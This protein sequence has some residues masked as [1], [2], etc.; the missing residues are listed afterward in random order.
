M[1]L[2]GL[3]CFLFG[4]VKSNN[5]RRHLKI[6][7]FNSTIASQPKIIVGLEGPTIESYPKIFLGES[8]CLPKPNMLI[9]IVA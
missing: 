1:G 6:P 9:R 3:L 2:L 5:A 4:N 8:W 7:E